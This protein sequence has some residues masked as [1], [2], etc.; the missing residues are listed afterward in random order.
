MKDLDFSFFVKQGYTKMD[1]NV[2]LISIFIGIIIASIA[3]VYRRYVLGNI[4][5]KIVEKK[6]FSQDN[7]N[8]RVQPL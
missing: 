3:I 1:L 7:A 6:A 5:K 2:I 4:V 8:Q